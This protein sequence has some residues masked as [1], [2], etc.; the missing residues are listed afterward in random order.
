MKSPFGSYSFGHPS[1]LAFNNG[2]TVGFAE[3]DLH[4]CLIDVFL[5]FIQQ[6]FRARFFCCYCGHVIHVHPD[7]GRCCP[8]FQHSPL[9]SY[10]D[11]QMMSFIA[12]V[13]SRGEMVQPTIIPVSR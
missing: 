8:L 12:M 11:A 3:F 13:N 5:E 7:R 1:E 4:W 9:T 10:C 2:N 6:V